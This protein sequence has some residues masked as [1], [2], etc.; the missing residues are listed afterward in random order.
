MK[1]SR[2]KNRFLMLLEKLEKAQK[3]HAEALAKLNE[4]IKSEKF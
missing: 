3:A 1:K 2:K 4:T